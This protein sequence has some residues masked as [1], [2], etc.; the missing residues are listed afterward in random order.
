MFYPYPPLKLPSGRGKSVMRNLTTVLDPSY[1]V[2]LNYHIII[3]SWQ[4]SHFLLLSSVIFKHYLWMGTISPLCLSTYSYKTSMYKVGANNFYNYDIS[5]MKAI[6]PLRFI[7][8]SKIQV[9]TLCTC[10]KEKISVNSA[11]THCYNPIVHSAYLKIVIKIWTVLD[12]CSE[13]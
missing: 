3:Q 4:N 11:G 1:I 7:E 2:P 9:R 10:L 12:D 6:F 13:C 5:K 8:Q